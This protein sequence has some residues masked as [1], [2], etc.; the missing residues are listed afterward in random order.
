M[1][2]FSDMDKRSVSDVISFFTHRTSDVE[3]FDELAKLGIDLWNPET[4]DRKK[5]M[6]I[7]KYHL[8]M[9]WPA[10]KSARVMRFVI[11]GEPL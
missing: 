1:K 5:L 3:Y 10:E 6:E 4:P 9:G 11:T 2:S 8:C 7:A